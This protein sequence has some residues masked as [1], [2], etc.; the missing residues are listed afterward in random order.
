VEREPI[1]IVGRGCVVP[2]AFDPDTF[3]ENIAAGRCSLAPASGGGFVRDFDASFDAAGFAAGAE[4]IMRLD[5]LYRWVLHAARQALREAGYASAP[6]PDAGLVLGN[7]S[8]PSAGLVTFAGQIWRQGRAS[9]GIDPRDRFSSGLPAHFA[10]RALGLG[11]GGFALD[12]ACASALYAIKLGCDRLHDGTASLMVAGAV[13]C[14]DRPLVHGGFRELGAV[15]PTGQSRP[16]HRAADGL[17]P[18][19]GAALVALMRL[20]DAVSVDAPI[21]GVIRAIGL[22]NDGRDGSLLAPSQEG[23]ERAMRLAYAAAGVPPRTVSLVECH[24]TGTPVGDAV[25]AR[26][27]ARV[28]ADCDD[29]PVGSVKSNVGHLLTAAGG[30]GLLKVLGAMRARVRPPSLS[31]DDP[32]KALGG[33]PLRL[34][35]EP[36]DWPG[37]RRCAVSA[38]GFGGTNAHLIVDEWVPGAD[39][40]AVRRTRRPDVPLAITAIGAKV[41]DGADA[42]DFRRAILLGERHAGPRSSIDVKLAGLRFPPR[43]LEVAHAQHVLVLEAAREAAG[44]IELPRERTTVVVGMG[45]DPEVA[46]YPVLGREGAAA[47]APFPGPAVLG[48]MPNLVANRINVQLNLAGPG[49]TVSAE[50]ASGLVA[51]ELAARA[52][53]CGEADAAVVGAVDLSCEPVHQAALRA[54]GRDRLPGDAAVVMILERLSDARRDG[55]PVIAV[56]DDMRSADGAPELLIGDKG[57]ADGAGSGGAAWFDPAELFGRAHAAHGLVAVAAAA[58]AVRHQAIPRPAELA[59]PVSGGLGALATVEPIGA[60]PVSVRLRSAGPPE[61]WAAGPAPRLRLYS[62]GDR[63]AV[64]EALAAGRESASGPARLAIIVDGHDDLPGRVEAARR[65]LAHDGPRP[66]AVAYRDAPLGGEIAFVFTNGS[67]A[68]PGMGAELALAFPA[69]ADAFEASHVRFRPRAGEAQAAMSPRGVVDRIVGAAVLCAFH[70]EL[71]R[72]LLRI[73]PDAAIGYSSG[74]SAALVALGAWSDPAAVHRDVQASDLLA[75]DLTGEFRAVRRA[76]RRLGVPGERW[77]SYLVSA[78]AD[79]VRAALGDEVAAYLMAVNAPDACIV[80]GEASACEAVLRRLGAAAVVPIDYGIAAHAPVLAEVAEEY[81]QLHLRPTADVPGVRFYSGAT[82]E[83]YRASADR[84]ADALLAQI[85]G[86]ID[87]VRVIERAWADGVR[88]FV[89]HGPQAQCTGWIRRILGERDHLSVALDAPR[90]RGTR[91][92][93]QVVAELIAAGVEA[94][95]AAFFDLL[96]TAAPAA[97]ART[98]AIRL[99]AHPPEMR[100]PGREPPTAAMPRA[101]RL[102]PVADSFQHGALIPG[103]ADGRAP[104]GPQRGSPAEAGGAM[105]GAADGFTAAAPDGVTSGGPDRGL[106]PAPPGVAGVVARQFLNVTALHRDFLAKQAQAHAEFLRARQQGVAALVALI[107]GSGAQPLGPLTGPHQPVPAERPAA[108]APAPGRP[109]VAASPTAPERPAAPAAASEP[110]A[111]AAPAAA[112]A[113]RAAPAPPGVLPASA[114]PGRTVPRGPTFDRAQVERLADGKV[115]ELFGPQF[116]VLDDRPKQTRL[117]KPPML[118]VDRVTGVDAVPGSMGTGTVWTETDIAPDGWYLDAAGR[119]AAGLMIEAGQADLLLISWLGIDLLGPGDRVYRLLGCE[120]TFHGSP[121]LAGETLRY[122][123]QIYQHA[124]HDGVRIFFFRYDCYVGDELRMTVRD[125]QAGF[126]TDDQLTSTEGLPWDV[127]Q[128][129]PD[130]RPLDPPTVPVVGRRFGADEVRA[131]AAGHPADCFGADWTA[132]RAHVRTPRISPGRMLR[133]DTVTD[134]DPAGGPL[135]RGYLRAEAAVA[136]DDWF[137]DGHFKNDPCM[138]GTLMFEGG[139]QAMAFYLAALGFTVDRDGWRFEPVPGEPCLVRCRRQ[140]S[141]ASRMIVYE[142]FVSALSSDPCPTLYADVLGTVDGVKAFHARRAAVRL[143]PDWPLDHWRQLGPP[144]VQPTAEPVPLPALGGLVGVRQDAAAYDASAYG[145]ARAGQPVL[146]DG[147]RQDYAALLACAWGRPTQAFGPG[148]ARFDGPRGIPH[149]PGPPYHFMTRI[150]ATEGS[151]AG[152]QPGSAATA[153]YDLPASVWYLEQNGA[154]TMPFCVLMEAALQPCG[155][156]AI[157]IGSVLTS[158][159][160]L[161]FRNLDGTGT[162]LRE[163][164]AGTAALRSRVELRDISR[165]GDVIIES[166][167]ATCT[168]LDG[169]A[170]GEVAFE[171]ETVFGFFPMQALASQVGLPPSTAER[172]G[173]AEPCEYSVDLR[174]RP[175]RFCAG[176]ARLPG[177]MLIMLDR[178]TGYWPDAGQA[179]LGRLRAEQDVKPGGWFFKAHFFQDPVMPGSLGIQ[180]M[181]HL[182]QWYL[183]ERGA[184]ADLADPRF[185]PI[186]TGHPLTWKYR[187]QVLPTD[188]CVTIE[189]EITSLGEDERGRY[190]TADGWLWVDGLRIYHV[191]DLG[192]RAVPGRH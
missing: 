188:G 182:L 181:C 27:M 80:G 105:P 106:A 100:L 56:L 122:E 35:A 64:L 187:G 121:P 179:G 73:R 130:D 57:A 46:R 17:V 62:G 110:P 91:H 107:R 93:C 155:W 178:V 131:F 144:T 13:S 174:T 44:G 47:E 135:R 41:A 72:G 76:W 98:E 24:A 74:E 183:I 71:T 191:S 28:F 8:Y 19:E 175:P 26:S 113:R 68:Y 166:F 30:A 171:M 61:P 81:R 31:A 66:D 138:P 114:P 37:P 168:M 45:V 102:V 50:E 67:A 18:S 192:M 58:T 117:P 60:V 65:W 63:A 6:L 177:P 153:D 78:P 108:A 156:L 185:E 161:R 25:E 94:D 85:L 36:E 167:T 119:V 157:Y 173:L 10:A 145:A 189:L 38:F 88:V 149:L 29:L 146:V 14:P 42:D 77:A 134:V 172:A 140:V 124:E 190:A 103:A 83:S 20:D 43:D 32:I 53:R 2:D 54:L 111:A 165:L 132:A 143:V 89:E 52:L 151:L 170:D 5:P 163:V 12:A 152:L 33:T 1:A 101:P 126:F 11:A 123:I 159:A 154:P 115:S 148:Y 9:A 82:G 87:F 97:A 84:A 70:A 129:S 184:T 127:T 15:S 118:L 3:W 176:P 90:G 95:A 162:V 7:L 16:F 79:Q 96:A 51:L 92:L 34:L 39:I 136:P 86:T 59:V 23:Q 49:Y 141:P 116:A 139:L 150:V 120:V 158:E 4:E 137:F 55:R 99:P 104:A 160:D 164:P 75:T 169:P 40:P 21:L 147:L 48:T 128:M 69:I 180:A 142:V 22:S 109:T 112:P 133:F 125:G 186:M